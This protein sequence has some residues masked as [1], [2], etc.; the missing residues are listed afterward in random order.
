MVNVWGPLIADG[1]RTAPGMRS[2]RM[3]FGCAGA[4]RFVWEQLNSCSQ[5]IAKK[6]LRVRLDMYLG[7]MGMP[8]AGKVL[9]RHY[10]TRKED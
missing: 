7:F 10:E 1:A 8:R 6:G 3:S 4:D 2:P 9:F 5:P